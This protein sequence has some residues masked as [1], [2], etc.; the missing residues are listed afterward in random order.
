[1]WQDIVRLLVGW[2]LMGAVIAFWY[3]VMASIG[4]F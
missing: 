2:G 4:T 3:W 1:M